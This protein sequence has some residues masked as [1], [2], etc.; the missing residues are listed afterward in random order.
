MFVKR[1]GIGNFRGAAVVITDATPSMI[2]HRRREF[3]SQHSKVQ[4]G[5]ARQ[6]VLRPASDGD[7]VP[8]QDAASPTRG[9]AQ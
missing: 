4:V 1:N 9:H 8:P 5:A 6:S 2:E 7:R 3:A